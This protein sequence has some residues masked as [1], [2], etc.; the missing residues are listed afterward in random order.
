M[1]SPRLD[2]YLVEQNLA[3][4]RARAI[5]MIRDGLVKVNGV[6]VRKPA[7]SVALAIDISVDDHEDYVSRG[8]K[9]LAA[10]I[11]EFAPPIKG[12]ICLD[13][14]ASTGGFSEVL[15]RAGAEK[16]YAVDVGSG[17]LHKRVADDPR[18]VNLEKTHANTLSRNIIAD[19]IDLVVCDVSFI[20]LRKVLGFAL[21]LAA[22]RAHVITLIKPQFELGPKKIGKGG[23]V[24]ASDLEIQALQEEIKLWFREQG[25]APSK[26]INSPIEGGDGNKEYLIAAAR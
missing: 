24:V 13:L 12:K 6:V 3:A 17:Q 22:P 7:T 18:V 14:G 19:P 15:L 2:L 25:W 20:G 16:I 21:A 4:S 9:K 26:V 8:A 10:A 5:A 23:I 1:K 11:A